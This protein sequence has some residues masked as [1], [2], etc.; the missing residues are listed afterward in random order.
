[1]RRVAVEVCVLV[2][3]DRGQRDLVIAQRRLIH[4]WL[5]RRPRLALGGD[6]V[7][8]PA[9][10]VV[11][12]VGGADPGKDLAVLGIRGQER[13]VV[14]VGPVQ[15]AN[16]QLD[17]PVGD[18][19]ETQVEGRMHD[20]PALL[21]RCRAEQLLQLRQHVVDKMRGLALA[22]A[23]LDVHLLLHV[24]GRC[25]ICLLPRERPRGH[26][27]IEHVLLALLGQVEMQHR[28]VGRGRLDEAG[29]ER[30]L[31]RGEVLGLFV[32]VSAGGSPQTVRAVPEIDAVQIH[33]EDLILRKALL[34]SD[35]EDHLVNLPGHRLLRREELDLH[36][37]LGDR[38]PALVQ[39]PVRDV[40]P[41]RAE[42]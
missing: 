34:E 28:V 3:E 24:L 37:L 16:A 25:G 14:D 41:Q 2:V 19:L 22:G 35:R 9:D 11:V 27:S 36:Q 20:Q 4:V 39:P 13:S 32:E 29:E 21:D 40:D 7:V 23:G 8:L 38:A 6:H 30:G 33:R 31:R 26:H 10:G 15:V 17:C 5:E 18:G 1:M 42:S 12:E